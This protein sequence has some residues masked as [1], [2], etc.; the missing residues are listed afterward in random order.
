[1]QSP[2]ML[3][4]VDAIAVVRFFWDSSGTRCRA[5]A[6]DAGGNLLA[7]VSVELPETTRRRIWTTNG[8]AAAHR[9]EQI[10]EQ[11]LRTMLELRG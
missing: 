9:V 6:F 1:M 11:H 4:M 7:E 10:A 2:S 8:P 5:V 3:V